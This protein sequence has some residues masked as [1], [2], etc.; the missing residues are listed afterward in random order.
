MKLTQLLLIL[1]LT[2]C[3]NHADDVEVKIDKIIKFKSEI[4]FAKGFSIDDSNKDFTL[5]H[6]NSNESKFNFS[7]SIYLKHSDKFDGT[8]K[9]V[10]TN[11]LS[12][13]ALQSTTYLSYLSI[14][15]K[16]SVVG[17][18]SGLQYINSVELN[19][20]INKDSIVEIGSNGSVLMET[21]LKV[22]PDLFLIYP[23]E[24]E[25]KEKYNSKGIETLLISEYLESTPLARLEWI[26]LFGML[27]NNNE[28]AYDYFNTVVAKYESLK[29]D[30]DSDKTMFF[31]LPFKESW[32]MPNSNSLTANLIADA[33]LNYVFSDT[34]ND[35]TTRSKELVWSKAMNCEYWVI[36]ASR[37]D[38]Y[39]LEDLK[40]EDPIYSEFPAVKNNRV[41]F[42]NTSTTGYFTMGIVEPDVM[43]EDLINISNSNY[44]SKY[45]KILN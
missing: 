11:K 40:A 30:I 3:I 27:M 35:N 37:P 45:F 10:L 12:S 24:L 16:L 18:V 22:N 39:S 44:T 21:L 42:C 28:K 38:D 1:I 36:I 23:F 5:I 31:N 6:I 41:I 2:S 33:G 34:I 25:S 9:K 20:K 13:L 14:L 4:K 26:K 29:S 7:D 43:L 19:K 8:D 15:N 17:A 32:N